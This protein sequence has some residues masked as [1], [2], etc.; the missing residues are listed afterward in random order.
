M[1]PFEPQ[2]FA[3][4]SPQPEILPRGHLDSYSAELAYAAEKAKVGFEVAY[5]GGDLKEAA[6]PFAR[7]IL[8][9]A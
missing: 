8:A 2:T 9:D 1:N 7:K 5:G 6:R 3:P 4:S